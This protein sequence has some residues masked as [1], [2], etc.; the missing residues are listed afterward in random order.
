[1]KTVGFIISHKNGEKRRAILP[2]DIK[3]N[4]K[5][6][7]QLYFETGYGESVH[8]SDDEYKS[9]GCH[10]V[11]REEALNCDVITDVKLG[12][13][14]YL[15]EIAPNKILFGWAHA[16][17]NIPFTSNILKNSH[18]V[19]AWEEIFEN[20]RY[21]FYRN[22]EVAG[23][24]A[25]MHA[26]RFCGKMPYD[27]KVAILGN[28]QTAKGALRVL[29][30]LGAEVDVYNRRL[31]QLFREKMFEYDVLVNCVMWDTSRTDR[32]I[33]KEDLKKMKPGTMIIDISCDPYLEIETS[34]PTP[35]D[36]PVYIID[37]VIHYTVD[38]T[39]GMFPITITKVLSEGIS[40]YV[41]Y[42]IEN[43]IE[44]YPQNL[45]TAVVI[46]DGHIR[47]ERITAFRMA[48]NEFC[49]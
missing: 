1:M 34:H 9:V 6:P 38:N 29:H 16:V 5:N 36:D 11:S 4:I 33:Y 3:A 19:I 35:I 31:E 15:D 37:G 22:R 26:Y 14:D 8:I 42:I 44:T 32:I 21:I 30:G 2:K 13:A 43:D 23:E 24:A 48:R 28:G 49:Q 41:D 46:E 39:P 25:I 17:Q 18:T 27:T 7:Q 10:I 47:D 20:G 40:R 45:H 12:D